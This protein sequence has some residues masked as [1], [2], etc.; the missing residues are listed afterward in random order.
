M[1]RART[2]THANEATR[3]R[4]KMA[5]TTQTMAITRLKTS[6]MLKNSGF[7]RGRRMEERTT[8]FEVAQLWST[9]GAASCTFY[10]DSLAVAMYRIFRFLLLD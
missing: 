1:A 7:S 4:M 10:I 9:K 6:A 3:I 2:Q 5:E 8:R